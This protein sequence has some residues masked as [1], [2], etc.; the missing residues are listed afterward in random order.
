MTFDPNYVYSLRSVNGSTGM[1]LN[2]T[3]R[4]YSNGNQVSSW[5]AVG[6]NKI[7][8]ADSGAR[9]GS[10]KMYFAESPNKCIDNP[11]GQTANGT[12]LQV[13]DCGSNNAWQQWFVSVDGPSGAAF[14]K[15]A[16]SGKCMDSRGFNT[17]T[18]SA[19]TI[20]D[21]NGGPTL[22]WR[23]TGG[24]WIPKGTQYDIHEN[25]DA[26]VLLAGNGD[27]NVAI[28]TGSNYN[29]GNKLRLAGIADTSLDDM[30]RI[31]PG[32]S[33]NTWIIKFVG[34]SANKCL[35][36]PGGQT[37][38]GT[39]PQL[40]DCNGGSNQ[41]WIFTNHPSDGALMVQNQY[42]G[43]CLDANNVEAPDGQT[44]IVLW[45]CS[46]ANINQLWGLSVN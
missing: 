43:N 35:E 27:G 11:G 4:N 40:W 17:A 7:V 1:S 20:S 46:S 8:F 12:Q 18:G 23:M 3:G 39:K 31:L 13:W 34:G 9:N 22:K 45:D 24:Y 33:P 5:R 28:D 6:S 37:A 44:P 14:I 41:N 19:P 38:N 21:C 36:N 2:V 29:N 30:V 10:Y 32:T 25:R 26:Y 42:S 16:G 15:N